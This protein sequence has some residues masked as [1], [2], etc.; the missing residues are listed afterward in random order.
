MIEVFKTNVME[1]QQ[2]GLL[3]MEL[4]RHLPGHDIHFDLQ[5]CD[6]VLRVEGGPFSPEEII[7]IIRGKGYRCEVLD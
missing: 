5:D 6:K 7:A 2:A 4:M 3:R 1:P